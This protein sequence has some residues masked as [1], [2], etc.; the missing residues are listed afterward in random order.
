MAI[1]FGYEVKKY[2]FFFCDDSAIK[3]FL[4]NNIFLF[5]FL[6][7]RYISTKPSGCAQGNICSVVRRMWFKRIASSSWYYWCCNYTIQS[8]FAFS[9]SQSMF[10]R[11]FFSCICIKHLSNFFKFNFQSRN[12]NRKNKN[13]VSEANFYFF[14][15][16][17]MAVIVTFF[18]NVFVISV[19]AHGLFGKTNRDVV[20]IQT[21]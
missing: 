13:E 20:C 10:S 8:S 15:E 7:V 9:L 3:H 4:L 5:Y 12:V 1:T 6:L 2:L 11:R 17:T 18:I 21:I 19:F 16:A 14:T